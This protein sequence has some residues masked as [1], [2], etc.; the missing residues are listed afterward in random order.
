MAKK[1]QQK[2][3]ESKDLKN[4]MLRRS[5]DRALNK[6]SKNNDKISFVAVAKEANVSRGFLYK[7]KDIK[8]KVNLY[9]EAQHSDAKVKTAVSPKSKDVVIGQ[10]YKRLDLL[11]KKLS[12]KETKIKALEKEVNHYKLMLFE[13]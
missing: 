11:E 6:L 10:L 4:K 12:K 8:D 1:K 5:I 3:T 2:N 9:I 7:H 13:D